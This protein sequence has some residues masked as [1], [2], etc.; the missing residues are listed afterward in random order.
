[1][2]FSLATTFRGLGVSR[3]LAKKIQKGSWE[4]NR[5]EVSPAPLKAS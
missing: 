4:E 1:M 2:Y 5:G 3:V